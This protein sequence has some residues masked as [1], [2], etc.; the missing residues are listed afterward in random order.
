ASVEQNAGVDQIN[1]ALAQ[2]DTVIQQ[3]A[4]ASEEM[5][6]TSEELS[7]QAEQMQSSMEFFKTD[8]VGRRDTI[9]LLEARPMAEG[10]HKVRVAHITEKAAAK[11]AVESKGDEKDSEF[12]EF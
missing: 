3:N 2:L 9:K 8:S 12:E 5:A 1:K 10:E 7:S 4:S 11:E 6:S